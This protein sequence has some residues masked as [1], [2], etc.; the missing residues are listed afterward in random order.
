M[1]QATLTTVIIWPLACV[2]GNTVCSLSAAPT[3]KP[4]PPSPHSLSAT[5]ISCEGNGKGHVDHQG[6]KK[7]PSQPVQPHSSFAL[8][9]TIQRGS[10][11]EGTWSKKKKPFLSAWFLPG[12]Y[13][14]IDYST[15][16]ISLMETLVTFKH[17]AVQPYWIPAETDST[18]LIPLLL[19]GMLLPIQ[20]IGK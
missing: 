19:R 4:F 13:S 17:T 7:P 11:K 15:I 18:S 6:M 20:K 12:C 8:L 16:K 3:I 1:L 10:N 2:G 5:E 9:F 14:P